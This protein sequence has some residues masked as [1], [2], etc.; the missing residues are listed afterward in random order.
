MS[1][2]GLC[3]KI[4]INKICDFVDFFVLCPLLFR[5]VWLLRCYCFHGVYVG[6]IYM[7]LVWG[8]IV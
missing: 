4:M 7:A 6:P 3:F 1:K 5:W 2:T 8:R